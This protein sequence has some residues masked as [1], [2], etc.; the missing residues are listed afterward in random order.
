MKTYETREYAVYTTCY[1]PHNR[2]PLSNESQWSNFE[3]I[4]RCRDI[5]RVSK[6][7]TLYCHCIHGVL[8]CKIITFLYFF[9][10][11]FS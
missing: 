7:Q 6:S 8:K 2:A 3:W 10:C 1:M 9:N 11:V 5:Q 4:S